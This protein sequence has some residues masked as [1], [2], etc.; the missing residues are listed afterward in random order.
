LLI[1]SKLV[2]GKEKKRK[3]TEREKKER[4]KERK[5]GTVEIKGASEFFKGEIFQVFFNFT[6]S[7][8]VAMLLFE[9][10]SYFNTFDPFFLILFILCVSKFKPPF[11]LI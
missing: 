3:G 4:D 1:K 5:K 11:S 2:K 7:I 9:L 10:P 8:K 6:P